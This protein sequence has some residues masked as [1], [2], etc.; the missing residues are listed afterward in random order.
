MKTKKIK[1]LQKIILSSLFINSV[2][3]ASVKVEESFGDQP[4]P[5]QIEG[6]PADVDV[7]KSKYKVQTEN[8]KFADYNHFF[9]FGPSTNDFGMGP[10]LGYAIKLSPKLKLGVLVGNIKSGTGMGASMQTEGGNLD[11]GQ[12]YV[13]KYYHNVDF[14]ALNISFYPR[15]EGAVRW[16]P[17]I[18]A[19]VGYA[20]I[21]S[22][23]HWARYDKDPAF[24][25][26]GGKRFREEGSTDVAWG[27]VY[28]KLGGYYQFVFNN[29]AQAR[30]GHILE[31]GAG[32][33][34]F[35]DTQTLSYTKPNGEFVEKKTPWASGFVDL[36]YTIAF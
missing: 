6:E 22:I 34:S 7:N 26:G 15:E 28:S 4:T 18:R 20:R 29:S 32:V 8:L 33:N 31:L 23:A 14:S 19:T 30:V 21:K 1:Y 16:G 2:G 5:S 17:F 11:T 3:Y 9:S 36:N 12:Y 13:E 10:T 24:F 27:T 35:S 25:F